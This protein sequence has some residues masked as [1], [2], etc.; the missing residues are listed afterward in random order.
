VWLYVW[1]YIFIPR[2]EQ[3]SNPFSGCCWA[4][5]LSYPLLHTAG[6]DSIFVGIKIS[7]FLSYCRWK[8]YNNV[9]VCVAESS[10]YIFYGWYLKKIRKELLS[11]SRQKKKNSKIVYKI[12]LSRLR[13]FKRFRTPYFVSFA[14]LI[15]VKEFF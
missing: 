3:T 4:N 7:F 11:L 2:A 9:V 8:K 15:S 13:V 14:S 10:V 6:L 1:K 12:F 5:F